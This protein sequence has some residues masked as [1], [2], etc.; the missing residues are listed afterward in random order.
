MKSVK[1]TQNIRSL[2]IGI[3]KGAYKVMAPQIF[4]TH[5]HFVLSVAVSQTKLCYSLFCVILRVDWFKSI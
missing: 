2:F 4:R 5:S 3:T 1:L